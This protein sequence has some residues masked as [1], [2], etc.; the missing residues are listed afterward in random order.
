M[1]VKPNEKNGLLPAGKAWPTARKRFGQSLLALMVMGL[2]V[3]PAWGQDTAAT[4]DNNMEE[5]VVTGQRSSIATSQ[6]LKQEAEQVVDVIS[7]VDIGALPDR[8][9]AEALQRIPG[10]QLERTTN[11]RDPARLASEG[12]DVMVRGLRWV[13]TELNGRDIFS[14]SGGRSLGFSDVS[15]DLLAGIDVYKNSTAGQIEGGLGGTVNLRTRLPLDQETT[16]AVSADYNYADLYDKGFTSWNALYSDRWD[17]GGGEIGFLV[18]VSVGEIGNRTD[19]IQTGRYNA[20]TLGDGSAVYLPTGVGGRRV[21]WEQDRDS[22]NAALQWAPSDDMKITAQAFYGKVN[23][24]DVERAV[25][26]ADSIFGQ[27]LSPG[28]GDDFQYD[29]NGF[30]ASGT[31]NA[32]TTVFNTRVENRESDVSDFSLKFEYAPNTRWNFSADLQSVKS[33]AHIL[34]MTAF[35]GYVPNAMTGLYPETVFDLTAPYISVG[36]Q[37]RLSSADQYWWGAAMDHIEDNEASSLAAR[38]DAEYIFENSSAL[39]SLA[40]GVRASDKDA[41]TKQSGWNWSLLS[42]QYWLNNTPENTAFLDSSAVG[43]SELFTFEDFMRG[44][45]APPTVGWFATPELVN[46]NTG[47]YVYFEDIVANNG[48]G[49]GWAPLI[50]PAAYDLNP[51]GDNVSAGINDQN[52]KTQAAYV[53]LFFNDSRGGENFDGNVGVRFVKTETTAIGRS[54]AGGVGDTCSTDMTADCQAAQ[55]FVDAFLA[56]HGEYRSYENSYNNVLPSLN[57][58]FLLTDDL[59]ARF[60]LSQALVRPQFSQIQ[61][62]TSVTF[63]FQGS[64]FDPNEPTVATAFGGNPALEPTIADQLDASLEWYFND[65]SSLTFAAFYKDIEDYVVLT[66]G[67]EEFSYGGETFEIETTRQTNAE[68]GKLKGFEL[69]YQQFYD[70]LPSPFDG[71]G[72]QANFTYIDNE[73]GANTAVN[74]FE[75][76]QRVGATNTTLPIEGMSDTSYNLALMYEKYGVSARLAYNWRERYLLTTSAANINRPMWINDYGQLDGS[77]FYDVTENLKVGLQ[78]TNLL[79]ERIEQEVMGDHPGTAPYSWTDTDRRTAFVV[80]YKF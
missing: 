20:Y 1:N 57:L 32:A 79:Q 65:A 35:T 49:W 40:F 16:L 53:S 9:I 67:I 17:T 51:Q 23:P 24:R 22:Y 63:N 46:S 50:P 27:D 39:R 68:S 62:Y 61:P 5:V 64:M 28:S 7:A 55:A 59:Q 13:R 43:Q 45:I 42:N 66:T 21:D 73:G 19:A 75:E 48:Q 29:S 54:V 14:A 36:E 72:I 3:V 60:G 76:P 34:S 47:A 80:R 70:M 15:A 71:F 77:V 44:D 12:G 2:V 8:S 69:A 25:Y 74:P 41:V 38:A 52:E 30:L 4:G 6:M 33:E 10:I 26:I 78:I 18:S 11:F 58:R 31:I 37:Q 56:E